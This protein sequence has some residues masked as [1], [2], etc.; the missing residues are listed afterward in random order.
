MTKHQ[1]NYLKEIQTMMDNGYI[2]VVECNHCNVS[3]ISNDREWLVKDWNMN[4]SFH[5][6]A[7]HITVY[8]NLKTGTN[9]E[10]I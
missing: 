5:D 7:G 2:H 9:E 3:Q 10:L 6:D 1:K 8:R 4:Q